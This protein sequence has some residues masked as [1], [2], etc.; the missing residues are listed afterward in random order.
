MLAIVESTLAMAFSKKATNINTHNDLHNART[1]CT[2]LKNIN[3]NS[4]LSRALNTSAVI[5]TKHLIFSDIFS[6]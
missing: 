5:Q 1:A 6:E 3:P 2:S 4:Y